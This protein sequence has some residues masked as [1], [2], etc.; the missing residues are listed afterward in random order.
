MSCIEHG[1][2]PCDIVLAYIVMVYIVLAYIVLAYIGLAYIGL[3]LYSYGLYSYGA[4]M[5]FTS[6]RSRRSH[7][8]ESE[9]DIELGGP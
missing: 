4:G 7:A 5:W 6:T 2:W 9:I 8:L 1:S 3:A